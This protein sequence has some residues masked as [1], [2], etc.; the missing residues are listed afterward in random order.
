[1]KFEV[2][3]KV[4][5]YE[6]A[7]EV[8]SFGQVKSLHR[9]F[10][11]P[12]QESIRSKTI[13]EKILKPYVGKTGYC[14][15]NLRAKDKASLSTIQ[16]L[17]ALAFMPNLENKPCVNHINGIKTDN[18]LENLEWV[19]HSENLTHAYQIGLRIPSSKRGYDFKGSLPI[20]QFTNDNI[21]VQDWPG[22]ME[23]Q[24]QTGIFQAN[25]SKCLRGMRKTAGSFIWKYKK[26]I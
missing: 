12:Y 26:S 18:R 11:R 16:R 20:S 24:R 10:E 7:Y 17:V 6:G 5:G 14:Y 8:S 9:V 21:W 13:Y 22:S 1:M 4:V 25:I 2:W 3:E 23:A 15:V 19:T